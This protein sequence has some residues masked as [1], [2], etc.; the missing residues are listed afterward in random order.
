MSQIT[1]RACTEVDENADFVSFGNKTRGDVR[2]D[3]TGSTSDEIA[4]HK[5]LRVE[6]GAPYGGK[7]TSKCAMMPEGSMRQLRPTNSLI[8]QQRDVARM[9]HE[10]QQE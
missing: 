9:R 8:R 6:I 7:L 4:S 10:L 1:Q 5:T 2:A 3:E